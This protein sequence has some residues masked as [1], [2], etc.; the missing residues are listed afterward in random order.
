M[1]QAAWIR[2]AESHLTEI[3]IQ[4][5]P[6]AVADLANIAPELDFKFHIT[7]TAEAE[8]PSNEVLK[9]INEVLRKV[10]DKLKFD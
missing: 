5:L 4:D 3:E 2:H 8:P 10:T 1:R 9:E 7:I 6:E